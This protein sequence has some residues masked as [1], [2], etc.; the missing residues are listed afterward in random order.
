[1]PAI[2][3]L[4]RI[5][6]AIY[7]ICRPELLSFLP[8]VDRIS[9]SM[10]VIVAVI[11]GLVLSM[12]TMSLAWALFRPE[13]LFLTLA[14]SGGLSFIDGTGTASKLLGRSN[15]PA[16]AILIGQVNCRRRRRRCCCHC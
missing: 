5:A 3:C 4:L 6:L 10:S 14:A 7:L 9:T 8:F 1:M 12:L 15:N 2:C 16:R 11:A 13:I